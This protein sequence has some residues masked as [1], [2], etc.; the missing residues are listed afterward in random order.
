MGGHAPTDSEIHRIDQEVDEY[1]DSDW[2]ICPLCNGSGEFIAGCQCN[3][4][5]GEGE[6]LIKEH[7]KRCID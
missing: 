3:N 5:A 1:G 7:E 4:C 2:M 6:V